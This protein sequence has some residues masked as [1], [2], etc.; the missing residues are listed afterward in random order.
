MKKLLVLTFLSLFLGNAFAEDVHQHHNKTKFLSLNEGK[1][2]EIDKTMKENMEAIY[3]KFKKL[4]ELTSSKKVTEK[5]YAELSNLISDS[6]QKIANNCKMEPKA[7]ETFHVVLGNLLAVSEDL[8]NQKKIKQATEKL[9]HALKVYS[10]Y[11][12][13]SFSK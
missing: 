3:A 4:N 9:S 5:D 11:F 7:D 12:N 1:K 6:A 13:H 10:E 8:K 2:W